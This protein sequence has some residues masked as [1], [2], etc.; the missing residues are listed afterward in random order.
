MST[1]EWIHYKTDPCYGASDPGGYQDIYNRANQQ[2]WANFTAHY[3]AGTTGAGEHDKDG[4]HFAD[5]LADM[6]GVEED[7][8]TGNGGD[9]TNISL[10]DSNLDVK[11][12][13]IWE[14]STGY[15]W[16][17]SEDMAG[18]L[19]FD[20]LNIADLTDCIQSVGTGTFQVG[21]TLN[22]NTRVYYYTVYG[23]TS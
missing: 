7:T 1:P 12:I 4:D 22:V 19:T 18:D 14:A 8:F 21:T 17:R 2:I 3:D 20:T 15:T 10:S 11:F 5:F 23:P 9:D 16:F 13:R 6:W